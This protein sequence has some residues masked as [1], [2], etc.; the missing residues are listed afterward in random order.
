MFERAP[1][2]V[3]KDNT[4]VSSG[5]AQVTRLV[6][7]PNLPPGSTPA[8]DLIEQVSNMLST[9]DWARHYEANPI[10]GNIAM[11][12]SSSARS[13]ILSLARSAEIATGLR[14]TYR[15]L[16]GLLSRVA[17][18]SA[19]GQM[20]RDELDEFI[21][22]NQPT[23]D[24]LERFKK[25]RRLA[26]LRG[27]QGIFGA[28]YGTPSV[29]ASRRD[30]VLRLMSQVDPVKDAIPGDAPTDP[31]QGWATPINDAFAGNYDET[32][33]LSYLHTRDEEGI[34]G[35]VVHDFDEILDSAYVDL[36]QDI[37]LKE[38]DRLEAIA[39]YGSYLMRL[40]A[41]AHGISAFRREVGVL[42]DAAFHSPNIPDGLAKALR[43]LIRPQR[44]PGE[45]ADESLL[46]LFDSRAE[47]I[48]GWAKSS[49]L[50]VLL[51]SLEM[52]TESVGPDQT[53]LIL[54]GQAKELGRMT[55]DFALVREALACVDDYAGVTNLVD[56]TSPRLERIRAVHL[57]SNVLADTQ[58]RIV[59]G[60]ES[61]IVTLKSQGEF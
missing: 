14:F 27:I 56:A 57:R 6:E 22:V 19:P 32:S 28:G 36:M 8:H 43:T 45:G 31:T 37:T 15:E 7:R 30:P 24:P 29:E 48:L 50:A 9:V 4:V 47:P 21:A 17:V 23:G 34:L 49:K 13:A 46:P 3:I 61:R 16:W 60:R 5:W 11:L 51:P 39:W 55:L 1:S 26:S 12:Q 53:V 2:T 44:R 40:Y 58:I 35:S 18:G 59:S 52:Q 20:G 41:M 10:A 33:P 25:L 54:R 42:L 38:G